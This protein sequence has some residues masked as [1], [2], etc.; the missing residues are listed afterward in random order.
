VIYLKWRKHESYIDVV[1][2]SLTAIVLG[3]FLQVL[4]RLNICAT[5]TRVGFAY[6]RQAERSALRANNTVSPLRA[7]VTSNAVP[8]SCHSGHSVIPISRL[9]GTQQFVDRLF[10]KYYQ[11]D[12]VKENDVGKAC[13]IHAKGKHRIVLVTHE[14][15]IS[16]GDSGVNGRILLNV[17]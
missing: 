13:S 17:S 4:N 12:Q 8:G 1:S 10:T 9:Q 11:G 6:A 5:H 2:K 7:N 15:N 16:I 3:G 14:E